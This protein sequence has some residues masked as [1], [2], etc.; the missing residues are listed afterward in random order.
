[1]KLL[2]RILLATD[3]SQ[4]SDDALQ[5]AVFVAKAFHSQMIPIHVI[6]EIQDSPLAI[7][8]VKKTVTKRLQEIKNSINKEGVNVVESIV[9][10]GTPSDQIIQ[11]AGVKDVN[12]I[13]VGS[14]EKGS[15]GKFRL[16]ITAGRLI[17]HSTKPVW[18]VKQ[19]TKPPIKKILCPVD[20]SNPA[21]RALANAIHL[22][23]NFQ[24]ELTVLMVTH[25]VSQLYPSMAKVEAKEQ[26]AYA[27]QEKSLFEQFLQKFD[28]YKISWNKLV[29]QGKP[30]EE[31]LRV[32]RET[33]CDV[34]VMGS[35]GRTKLKRMLMGS[36][37]EKVTRVVP[38]SII[39][40]KSEHAVRLQLEE[41]IDIIKTQCDQGLELLEKGFPAEA[42]QRFQ[43]CITRDKL[44]AL[45]W[46]GLAA[47]HKRLGHD[48]ESKRC[49]DIAKSI[50]QATWEKKVTA[51]VR[52]QLWGKKP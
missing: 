17:R 47:S 7:E 10:S 49:M 6:P 36:V 44:Y 1:M 14:G 52:K 23:R 31:I 9:V 12:V 35:M 16:G 42:V 13:I 50:R 27:K 30:H 29:K 28:F 18:V 38:C 5:M 33:Q 22:A 41:E 26:Q 20:F 45:A 32:A 51:E 8:M 19:G 43:N 37:A 25:R 24:A 15:E 21:A 3:F 2:E 40:V 11:H 4:A 34:I 48:E 39:T 46:E